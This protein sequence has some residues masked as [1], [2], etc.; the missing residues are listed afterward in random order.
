MSQISHNEFECTLCNYTTSKKSDYGKHIATRKHLLL[1]NTKNTTTKNTTTKNNTTN[2]ISEHKRHPCSCGKEYK[3]SSSLSF[4]K[5]TCLDI[6]EAKQKKTCDKEDTPNNVIM[7][8][9]E[10]NKDLKD[11]IIT[12]QQQH[13]EQQEKQ[14]REAYE[15]QEKMMEMMTKQMSEI[16]PKLGNNNNNNTSNKIINNTK[17]KFNLKIFLNET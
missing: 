10:A 6:I 16:F 13:Y 11:I 12:Q 9:I 3:F 15:Q 4:H 7:Q 17:N 8:I 5:K 14:K 2:S 1:A